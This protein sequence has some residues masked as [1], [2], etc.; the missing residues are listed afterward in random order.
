VDDP[1][2]III[3][4]QYVKA[5]DCFLDRIREGI[6][7]IGLPDVDKRVRIEYSTLGEERG[8]LGGAAFLISD[9]FNR[10][11]LFQSG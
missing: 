5:G 1:E 8:V 6:R 10:Q 9:F 7:H 11:L 2:L 4:G 3:Q